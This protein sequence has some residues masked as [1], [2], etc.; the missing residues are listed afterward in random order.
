MNYALLQLKGGQITII[1]NSTNIGK[2]RICRLIDEGA[3]SVGTIESDLR[4][5]ELK[6][7]FEKYMREEYEQQCDKVR[8]ARQALDGDITWDEVHPPKEESRWK[9]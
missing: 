8:L 5:S 7:G 4:P 2:G 9:N 6:R 1:D 3:L